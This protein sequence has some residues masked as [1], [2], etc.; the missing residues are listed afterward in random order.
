MLR[1]QL[2]FFENTFCDKIRA[3]KA[4]GTRSPL[5]ERECVRRLVYYVGR[6]L[7]AGNPAVPADAAR[8]SIIRSIRT[9]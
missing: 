4:S 5:A 9:G 6:F 3:V 2:F 8:Q 7:G 1:S